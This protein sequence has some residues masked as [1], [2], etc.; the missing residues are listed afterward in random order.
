[1][2]ILI[3]YH[4]AQETNIIPFLYWDLT[5]KC[6]ICIWQLQQCMEYFGPILGV[7]CSTF[8]SNKS[9][10]IVTFVYF[11]KIR[12][13]YL[14]YKMITSQNAPSESLFLFLTIPWFTKSVASRWVLVHE[15][16]SIFEYLLNHNLLTH[17]TWPVDRY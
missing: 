16:G 1:M 5:N 6:T 11:R 9:P 10:N 4:D 17:Q 3:S 8:W 12:R 7:R 2:L 14:C 15:T 13:G